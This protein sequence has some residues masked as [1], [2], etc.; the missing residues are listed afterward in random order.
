MFYNGSKW[1]KTLTSTIL[2][3]NNS[4]QLKSNKNDQLHY[5]INHKSASNW[6]Q[7]LAHSLL[8]LALA[9]QLTHRI[10]YPFSSENAHASTCLLLFIFFNHIFGNDLLLQCCRYKYQ[11]NRKEFHIYHCSV[12]FL[13]LSK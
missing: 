12:P 10:F 7:G 5:S 13:G 9:W 6:Q 11:A 8:M 4:T 3:M 1:G 2:Q